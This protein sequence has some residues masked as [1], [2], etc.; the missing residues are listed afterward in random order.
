MMKEANDAELFVGNI[1]FTV[2]QDQLGQ[3]F[4]KY[5]ELASVKLLERVLKVFIV[6]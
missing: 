4:A 3:F 5:G 1:P 2:S 6:E